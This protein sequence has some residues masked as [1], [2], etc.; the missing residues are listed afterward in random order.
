MKHLLSL[1]LSLALTWWLLSG[2]AQPLLLDLGAA[3]VLFCV[4]L[5]SRMDVIDRE[6]H[7]L[8]LSVGLVRFWLL[9]LRDIVTS[10]IQVVRLIWSPRM[11][12]SPEV[13]SVKTRLRDELGQVILANAITLTPG[14]V[15]MLV[16]NDEL[17]IH[18]LTRASADEIRAGTMDSRVPI[19]TEAE[20]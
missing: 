2:F 17:L 9:L 6:S 16:D 15:T 12:L 20:S 8:H 4:W 14:T 1:L 13:L 3:S 10:N 19:D 18:A 11:A 5:A 7:P